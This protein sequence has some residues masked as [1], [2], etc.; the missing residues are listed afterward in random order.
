MG[1]KQETLSEASSIIKKFCGLTDNLTS[2]DICIETQNIYLSGMCQRRGIT[3][4]STIT[5][6]HTNLA[7]PAQ[8]HSV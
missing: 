2:T 6:K 3:N 1:G 4:C 7:I 8:W 5:K